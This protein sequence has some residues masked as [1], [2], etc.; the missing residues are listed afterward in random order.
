[1]IETICFNPLLIL[2]AIKFYTP[3]TITV[4]KFPPFRVHQQVK[5]PG[6]LPQVGGGA[7]GGGAGEERG[8]AGGS[9][10]GAGGSGG[11]GGRSGGVS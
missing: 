4:V 1:M 9:G 3:I 8:G 11:S 10:G 6:F 7:G 2:Y 5:Y